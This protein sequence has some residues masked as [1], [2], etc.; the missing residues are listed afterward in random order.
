MGQN[1]SVTIQAP[2]PR[3][4]ILKSNQGTKF[5]ALKK[6]ASILFDVIIFSFNGKIKQI[7]R[8]TTSSEQCLK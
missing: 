8:G 4:L 5:G 2:T 1:S 6:P 3:I 7:F